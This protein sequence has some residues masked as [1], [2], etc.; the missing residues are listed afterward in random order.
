MTISASA[1]VLLQMVLTPAS[2]ALAPGSSAQFAVSGSWSDGSTT[3]P[4]VTYSATGGTITVGGLY[5]AG[6]AAGTFRVIATQQG[7]TKAD[8]ATVSIAA[9]APTLTRLAISPKTLALAF[10]ATQQ[11]SVAGS[12][13]DGSSAPPSVSFLATGGTI[14]NTGMFTA[15]TTAG[16]FRVIAAQTGGTKTDTA[17]V[18]VTPP[19]TLMVNAGASQTISSTDSAVLNA[20]VVSPSGG[21]LKMYWSKISGPGTA[22]F[23]NESFSS[24]FEDGT[25]NAWLADNGG[26]QTGAGSV[27]QDQAHSGTFSW[28]AYNDPQL[29][30]PAD[31]SAKLLR[32]R[33]DYPA[34]YY[35]AWYYWPT[36]YVVNGVPDQYVNFFQFKERTAPYDPTWIVAAKNAVDGSGADDIVLH[37]WHGAVIYRTTPGTRVPKGRWFHIT[38]YMKVGR[39]D[40]AIIIW[41]DNAII[42]RRSG[43][44]TVGSITNVNPPFL[45]WGVGNYGTTGIGRSLYVDDASVADATIDPRHTSVRFSARGV[46]VLRLTASDG[47]DNV[48]SDTQITVR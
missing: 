25:V 41:L 27:S 20:T 4:A 10:G 12:W 18:T 48:S 34:A 24:S 6:A 30:Y 29:P 44:N 21:P 16:T 23:A 40:G 9:A 46:Y 38:A 2:L 31:E 33:F 22:T 43:I 32:W 35:S 47:Q 45:M 3:T 19:T 8:T 11:F 39:T 26:S 15:G 37:D 36:D 42:F 1:A 17:S 5:T 28:K 13:S 7:G 14:T